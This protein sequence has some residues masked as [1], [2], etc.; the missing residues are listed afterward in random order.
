MIAALMPE[1]VAVAEAFGDLPDARLFPGEETAVRN[2]VDARRREYTTVRHLARRAMA[3]L[4]LPAVAVLSGARHEPLWPSGVVG[5]MTHTLGYR[6]AALS[7]DDRHASLGIDAERHAPLPR[8]VLAKIAHPAEVPRLAELTAAYP[9]VHWDTLLFSAKEAVYKAW[10]PLAGG[11]LAFQ[12]T[13]LDF[14]PGSEGFTAALRRPGPAEAGYPLT[15]MTG[16]WYVH[17]GLVFSAV[18]VARATP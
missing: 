12:E 10:Y 8:G 7:L 5:S 1:G 4:G 6:A 16:R 17:G 11:T 3:D 18:T 2:A 13:E 9:E 15:R 14:D